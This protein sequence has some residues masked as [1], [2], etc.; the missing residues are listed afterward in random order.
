MSTNSV[1]D[2]SDVAGSNTDVAGNG[3][4]GSSNISLGNDVFQNIMAQIAAGLI[5]RGSDIATASTISFTGATT[6]ALTHDL[7]GTTTVTAV[8]LTAGHWRICRAQGAFQLTASSTLVVNGSTSTN[9]TTTAG[10]LLV[11]FGY[12]SSTV[13]V[14]TFSGGTA[15]AAT[16]S[17]A[18]IV[19]L[20]TTTEALTGTNATKAVTPAG[21][22]FPTG[23]LYGL[24]LTNNAGS[25]ANKIDIAA[26]TAR[27]DSDTYNMVLGAAI[28]AKDV[29]SS[30]AVGSS[31]G[32]LDTGSVGNNTYYVWLI[33]RT[34]TGVVD[35][36]FSLSSTA[37]TMPTNYTAK[38]LIGSF[39]RVSA[40]NQAPRAFS[41]DRLGPSSFVAYTPTF[42]G[43]GTVASSAFFSRRVG[44]M[45]QIIGTC[46]IGTPTATTTQI[47]L[48]YNGTNANVTI[49]STVAA[50]VKLLGSY[51]LSVAQAAS[52]YVIGTGGNG[53]INI[54][55]SNA[56]AS[57]LTAANL[58]GAGSGITLAINAMVPISGW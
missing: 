48:G 23:H 30:W 14:W 16:T 50:S 27:D 57:G 26:G 55:Q 49:D 6:R 20:A 17:A 11:F 43:L 31:A 7:T 5:E 58:S 40:S 51:T 39:A 29:T 53:Y 2:W 13:R 8:T 34:D 19:Q 52:Q 41:D 33:K 44:S 18:G 22:Y 24:T 9:Y 54:S 32:G 21:L 12:S 36:L 46:V 15:A 1:F 3:I 56:S 10:D 28:T 42:T 38:R 45:L 47:T 35:V 4:S 25:T 37:P